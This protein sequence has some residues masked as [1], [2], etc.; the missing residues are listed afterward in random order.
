MYTKEKVENLVENLRENL[1]KTTKELELCP[2]GR[3]RKEKSGKYTKYIHETAASKQGIGRKPELIRALTRKKYLEIQK[4]HLE[5][6]ISVLE[7]AGGKL[8][9]YD[10]AS[11]REETAAAFRGISE[12][13]MD[14]SERP[15]KNGGSGTPEISRT[16]RHAIETKTLSASQVEEI[17]EIQRAWAEA[18]YRMSDRNPE[19]RTMTTS[20]G[21]KV[22]SKSEVIIAELLY[23]Y[24]V[25]FRYEQL[26]FVGGNVVL[27]PDFT[28]LNVIDGEHYWEHAGMLEDPEY[29]KRHLWKK[30]IY[31]S[32]GIYPWKNYIETYDNEEG[33]CDADIVEAEIRGKLLKRLLLK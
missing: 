7:K 9:A 4:A 28:F 19:R 1:Q 25:P 31:E 20:R 17:R 13:Y 8:K 11:M 12:E 5:N 33:S 3:L 16:L 18:P 2:E 29:L 24:D 22:R 26:L 15:L 10:F 30:G 14:W 27:A 21:L 6:D 32:V 23:K